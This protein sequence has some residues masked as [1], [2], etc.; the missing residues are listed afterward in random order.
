MLVAQSCPILCDLMDY[1]PL[2]SSV[3]GIL[4]VRVL[5]WVAIPFSKGSSWPRDQTHL[6]CIAGRFIRIKQNK[7][8]VTL[9]FKLVSCIYFGHFYPNSVER[10]LV[11]SLSVAEVFRYDAQ[12]HHVSDLEHILWISG[13]STLE[14]SF[15]L[16]WAKV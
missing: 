4:Q 13:V 5:E 15:F 1:S 11:P 8:L 9:I 14:M 3:H 2:S 12:I 16:P 6:S 10:K 7:I